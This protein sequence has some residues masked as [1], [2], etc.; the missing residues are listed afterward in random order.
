MVSGMKAPAVGNKAPDDFVA[1][2]VNLDECAFLESAGQSF[3]DGGF[4]YTVGSEYLDDDGGLGL[5]LF[6]RV[7]GVVHFRISKWVPLRQAQDRRLR[8]LPG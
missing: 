3:P 2:L 8:T 7:Q 6:I 5:C 1:Q 4:A